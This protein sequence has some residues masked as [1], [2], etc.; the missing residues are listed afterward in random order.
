MF[1][2]TNL[3]C[4]QQFFSRFENVEDGD[5]VQFDKRKHLLWEN[6]LGDLLS[7]LCEPRPCANKI[8]DIA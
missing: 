2:I 5:C 1:H 6:R 8:V 4:V 3:V 7:Y